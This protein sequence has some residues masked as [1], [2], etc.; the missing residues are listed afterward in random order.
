M[1]DIQRRE[2]LKKGAVASGVLTVGGVAFAG[3]AAGKKKAVAY[4]RENNS[5]NPPSMGDQFVLHGNGGEK[6]RPCNNGKGKGHKVTKWI[7]GNNSPATNVMVQ[8][9]SLDLEVGDTVE[10]AKAIHDC[11]SGFTKVQI[12]EV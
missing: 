2:L 7:A 12:T 3:N 8:S 6:R 1:T 4:I 5:G 11:D 10:V 9:N